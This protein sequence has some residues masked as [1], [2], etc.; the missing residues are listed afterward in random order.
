MFFTTKFICLFDVPGAEFAQTSGGPRLGKRRQAVFRGW[1]R[2]RR[3]VLDVSESAAL[4]HQPPL[5]PPTTSPASAGHQPLGTAVKHGIPSPTP[6]PTAQHVRLLPT[7]TGPRLVVWRPA[8][9]RRIPW[10]L[11]E[12]G[13]RRVWRSLHQ[14]R[15]PLG[16]S[17][18]TE[19][20]LTEIVRIFR[21]GNYPK[22]YLC[23]NRHLFYFTKARNQWFHLK[24]K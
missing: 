11:P 22:F 23:W 10:S 9:G 5:P 12:P 21:H 13:D 24:V 14:R 19:W 15:P 6:T 17:G 2:K 4:C 20:K 8:R 7:L 1:K 18:M 3:W 16:N